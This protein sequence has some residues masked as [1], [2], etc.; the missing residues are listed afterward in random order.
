MKLVMFV[1]RIKDVFLN[2]DLIRK[3]QLK[4]QYDKIGNKDASFAI[5]INL[6]NNESIVYS[7]GVGDD[8]SFDVGLI[9][10]YRLK[11]YAFDPTPRSIEW[12][13]KNPS[14]PESFIFNPWGISNEDKIEK[15]YPPLVDAHVS[16]SI[17]NIQNSNAKYIE[18]QVYKLGTIMKKLN[19]GKID[20]LKMD[21]EGKEY[22]VLDDILESE[23]YIGQIVVE[24][25]HRYDK[26][27][28]NKT[29]NIINKLNLKGYKIFYISDNGE[30]YSFIKK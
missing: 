1:K 19:H 25:H 17:N 26:I 23:N 24:F 28:A 4:I 22:E 18:G 14:I 8:I 2:K 9:K 11:V 12:V 10:M 16:F 5:A 21:I 30:E 15:F 20:L 3:R 6:L 7:F 29:K 13:E 27:G